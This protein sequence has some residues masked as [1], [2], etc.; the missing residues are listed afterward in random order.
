MRNTDFI[1]STDAKFYPWQANLFTYLSKNLAKWKIPADE[2]TPVAELRTPFITAYAAW[3]DPEK[4]T[5]AVTRTKNETRDAYKKGLRDFLKEHVTYNKLV[6]NADRE[7]MELPVHDTTPTHIVD[8]TTM[9]VGE[10]D[11]SVHQRHAIRVIDSVTPGRGLP[12]GVS[13][14]ETWRVVGGE[15]P[16][17]AD[18][19]TFA[20]ISTRAT[21]VLDYPMEDVGKTVHYRFRWINPRGK[22]GPWSE[23][24][25]SAVIA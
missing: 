13:G 22:H 6:T 23:D 17:H 16:K 2:I 15:T 11:P 7:N 10:V 21:I 1:P 9:P 20:G 4:R 25:L 12:P 19:F 18:E 14:F 5:S 24:I 3:L 8:P